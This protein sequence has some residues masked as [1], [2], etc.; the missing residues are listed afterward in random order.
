MD[1]DANLPTDSDEDEEWAATGNIAGDGGETS[2]GI[3]RQARYEAW[4]VREIKRILRDK[5][6][7]EAYEKE[8]Q[9]VERRR[10][11]TDEER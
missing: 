3:K 7:S 1:S 9:E 11:M 6:E 4:K 10:K 8:L 2:I 5:E